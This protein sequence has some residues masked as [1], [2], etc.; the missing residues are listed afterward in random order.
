MPIPIPMDW[1]IERSTKRRNDVGAT[2]RRLLEAMGL[3]QDEVCEHL[4]RIEE[5]K[6]YLSERVGRDVGMP[7]ALIDYYTN[8]QPRGVVAP[9]GRF[10]P[11]EATTSTLLAPVFGLEEILS[12]FVQSVRGNR[13]VVL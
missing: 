11:I 1:V 5:H 4:P 8:I 6:W 10:H 13:Q 12:E 7:V 3:S 9:K 2:E